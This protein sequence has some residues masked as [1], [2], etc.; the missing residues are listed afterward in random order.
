MLSTSEDAGFYS[1]NRDHSETGESDGTQDILTCG[2]CQKTFALSDIVRFIQHKVLQCNKENYGQCFT[3]GSSGGA[4]RDSDDGRR[5]ML[6]NTSGGLATRRASMPNVSSRSVSSKQANSTSTFDRVHTP[7]PTSPAELLRDGASSTPKRLGDEPENASTHCASRGASPLG[8]SLDDEH[9]QKP[10]VRAIEIKQERMEVDPRPEDLDYVSRKQQ[11]TAQ[12]PRRNGS[13]DRADDM[14]LR[15]SRTPSTVSDGPEPHTVNSEPSNYVCSTCKTKYHSAWRLVQHVQHAHGVKIYVESLASTGNQ[16]G[17][18][19]PTEDSDA[20]ESA[21]ASDEAT[22]RDE[23]ETICSERCATDTSEM[24]PVDSASPAITTSPRPASRCASRSRRDVSL[25]TTTEEKDQARDVREKDSQEKVTMN[26]VERKEQRVLN[27][28]GYGSDEEIEVRPKRT[29]LSNV[30]N[31][32]SDGGEGKVSTGS[33]KE[34]IALS[35]TSPQA[36]MAPSA[37]S[38]QSTTPQPPSMQSPSHH[39]SPPASSVPASSSAMATVTTPITTT[40]ARSE[41]TQ[42]LPPPGLRGHHT[43]LPP[44]EIHQNPFGLLR[45]PHHPHNPL[46][47]RAAHH[48]FRMEHLMSE[49]FRNH[50]LNLAAA[51]VAAA[52]QLK[53]HSQPFTPA[54]GA[55][56]SERPPSAGAAAAAAAALTLTPGVPGLEPHMDYYSQ[57]L[58]Q[59][60]GTTSPGAN[61]TSNS[62]NSPSPRKQPHSPSHFASP[63]PSQLPPTPLTNNSRP[64]SL[65][66]PEKHTE[67]GLDAGS[68]MANTPRSASTPPN[69]QSQH[70]NHQASDGALYSCDF[71]GKKFRFQSNLLVHRRTHTNELPFKCTSCDFSCAQASKLKSHM[72]LVHSRTRPSVAI[73]EPDTASNVDSIESDSDDS[74]HDLMDADDLDADGRDGED[75]HMAHDGDGEDDDDDEDD[76]EDDEAEDLSMSSTQSQ[77]KKDGGSLQMSTSLVGE[78]MDKFGL[79]N[80][81]QY[82]EAYKQALQES[83]NALKLQL[84]SKDRDN[85]NSAMAIPGLAEKLNGLPTALRIKEELAKNMLQHHNPQLPQVPLFN[86]FEN[87]FEASKRMKL[88]GG[89]SWWG[90]PGLHRNESLFENMKPGRDGGVRGPSGGGGLLQP[91]MKKE[92]KLRNDTCE[93]C[94]K[95]FKNCSNLTVHRRSHTGEKPYKCELCSYACAQS[96][97]LTR[98]MKTHGRLGK[99]VYRCRFCEMPFS[100]PSTLEKHMRKCVVNQGKL[101]QQQQRELQQLQQQQQQLHHQQLAAQ[102]MAAAAAAAAQRDRDHHRDRERD[103]DREQHHQ[104]LHHQSQQQQSAAILAAAAAASPSHAGAPQIPPGLLLPPLPA[105]VAAAAAAAAGVSP[106]DENLTS[107]SPSSS[108]SSAA[109][110]AAAAAA[111]LMKEEAASA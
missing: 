40:P 41:S 78:L 16:D 96:S 25:D 11:T 17:G 62:S 19:A 54:T 77:S 31:S 20:P 109:A 74:D 111:A 71:C 30:S 55:T 49:Q 21:A 36:L 102:Q 50:G 88:E 6:A 67:L 87:P 1:H 92:S 75:R 35:L 73:S 39:Q 83:G 93:F 76:D 66:P 45:M 81:A 72:K 104:H 101:Q 63:S 44:P 51:A 33:P 46:F 100:V 68:L 57:R 24:L 105:A 47:G 10:S 79:S 97:K 38:R 4:D 13:L 34:V 8:C 80:I 53:S 26:G 106:T 95:V 84:T 61:I 89:E 82:S 3:Q 60:A 58:R 59:L 9:D 85:N 108:S 12:S 107:G 42:S 27:G 37:A 98:H 22:P 56:A 29:K 18:A 65:T 2:S 43:L 91:M 69:K 23:P 28:D 103:R 99:D 48:D 110:A 52:N 86:P 32:S 15:K 70:H 90:I 7:P 5:L 94:G 64:Q 14:A